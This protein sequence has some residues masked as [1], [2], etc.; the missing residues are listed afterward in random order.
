MQANQISVKEF[1]KKHKERVSLV[2][3]ALAFLLFIGG[4]IYL[5][6]SN[7]REKEPPAA[8]TL[9]SIEL[10]PTQ[11]QK[12]Q[13]ASEPKAAKVSYFLKPSAEELLAQLTSM[14]NLNEDV[15]NAKFSHL[16]VLWQAYFFALQETEDG[17][18]RILLD[19]SEDGFGV[20]LESEVDPGSYPQLRELISGE[21]I[22]IGGEILAVDRTGT[23]T[24]YLKTDQLMFG[25]EAPF[26]QTLQETQK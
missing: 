25:G 9:I 18:T 1:I 2:G 19:V 15:I 8:F 13:R 21:K 5:Q 20:V 7:K 14:E 11:K 10:K 4:G 12:G 23:G 17:L 6:K 26:P 22:W 16:P 3:V 24:I